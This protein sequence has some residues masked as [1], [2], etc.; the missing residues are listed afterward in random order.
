VNSVSDGI[1]TYR[2]VATDAAGNTATSAD[3]T[4][5][6][7]TGPPETTLTSGASG[8]IATATPTFEFG[9][10]PGAT[11]EC[12][13][14]TGDY[15]ACASP[16]TTATL[17]DGPHTFD[18]RAVDFAGNR[19]ATPEHREFSIDTTPPAEPTV[20]SGPSGATTESAPAF[21]FSG[22]PDATKVECR[23]DGPGGAGAFEACVSP[24]G[25]SALAPGDYV[26]LVRAT[27]AAGNSKTSQR[28]FT[29]TTVQQQQPPPPPT[30]TPTPTPTPAATPKPTPVPQQ[31]VVVAPAVGTVLVKVKGSSKFEPLDVTKGIPLGSEV[32]ATKGHVTLTVIQ[33]PGQPPQTAEF[34][35]G[36]FI[37]TQRGGVTDVKL[38]QPLSCPKG[39]AKAASGKKVKTRRLW[40]SGK[41]NFRTSGR[42][43]SAT[44]RGTQWRVTDTCRTTVTKVK[45]GV[46]SV[47]DFAKRKKVLV[48]APKSYTAREKKKKK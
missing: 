7:D 11:F 34:W 40:G 39:K 44:V 1:H 19:D 3:R 36:F 26:F 43:S 17:A 23:L 10:E 4:F 45:Q 42:L 15:A 41:G 25:F 20:T 33:K 30:Q 12:R 46:V 38:S 2:A 35:D 37:V 9:S 28:S 32:D 18:V 13:V 22:S 31:T 5:R 21:A 8:L 24:R 27:D 47:R 6:V 29:V 48:K 14:D 16:F